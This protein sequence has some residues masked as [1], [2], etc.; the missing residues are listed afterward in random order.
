MAPLF[1]KQTIR[2]VLRQFITSIGIGL[3]GL[4]I[5]AIA[6]RW[7]VDELGS[8]EERTYLTM[9]VYVG[10]FLG[11]CF[12][13]YT[14]LKTVGRQR[15]CIRFILQGILPRTFAQLV[16]VIAPLAGLILG[17]NYNLVNQN[18]KERNDKK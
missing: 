7:F 17:F 1:K 11:I 2:L 15:E 9:T 4:L 16:V 13:G 8:V 18:K 14:F 10:M 12:G 6:V 5:S 3:I